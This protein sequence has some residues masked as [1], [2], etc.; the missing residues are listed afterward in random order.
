[1][2]RMHNRVEHAGKVVLD[3]HALRK[4]RGA[5]FTPASLANFVSRWAIQDP[6]DRVLEPSCGEA[7]F[8]MSAAARLDELGALRE[9]QQLEGIEIHPP[10]AKSAA[11]LV[12][13]TGRPAKIKVAD[14]F[15]VPSARL[16]DA[17]IGNP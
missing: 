11:G 1:M 17:V 13:S 8:L 15:A 12:A 4:A 16:F 5:F 14:F 7:A 6:S 3:P 9:Q 10:S 2:T